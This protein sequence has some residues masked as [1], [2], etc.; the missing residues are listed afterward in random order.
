MNI[1]PDILRKET[2]QLIRQIDAQI[3]EIKAESTRMGKVPSELRDSTGNWVL[4]PLLLAKAQAY[5]TLVLLQA[6]K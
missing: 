3:E 4:S 1:S 5:N 2:V 6:K